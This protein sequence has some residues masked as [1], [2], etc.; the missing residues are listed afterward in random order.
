[1]ECGDEE[2]S[3]SVE[4]EESESGEESS[5]AADPVGFSFWRRNFEMLFKTIPDW[6]S[7]SAAVLAIGGV[8]LRELFFSHPEVISQFAPCTWRRMYISAC[9]IECH[10]HEH[11]QRLKARSESVN[12]NA[13]SSPTTTSSWRWIDFLSP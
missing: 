4:Q 3:R 13:S 10:K 2:E 9:R 11:A 5:L 1:M 6:I 8:P 7:R 12:C